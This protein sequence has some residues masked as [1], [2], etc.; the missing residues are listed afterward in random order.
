MKRKLIEMKREIGKSM[1]IVEDI[2]FLAVDGT[3][4]NSA[5]YI[6]LE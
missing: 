4:A 6:R 3:I 2:T 1:V 5:G